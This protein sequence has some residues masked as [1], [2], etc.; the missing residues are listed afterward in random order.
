M[1]TESPPAS[2]LERKISAALK[3]R[4][5]RAARG[6]APARVRNLNSILM[7]F[8]HVKV[9][10]EKMRSAFRAVDV[11]ESGSID[12]DESV[13]YVRGTVRCSS[14]AKSSRLAS[15]CLEKSSPQIGIASIKGM[16][17]TF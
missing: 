3:R 2:V 17:T 7:K 1:H 8:P 6:E 16:E 15:V 4:I 5:A 13:A 14:L 11:D 12:F 10:Y 9:G